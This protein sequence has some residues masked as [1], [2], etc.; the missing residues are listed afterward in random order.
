MVTSPSSQQHDRPHRRAAA[1]G[2]DLPVRGIEPAGRGTGSVRRAVRPAAAIRC[3][4]SRCRRAPAHT[5]IRLHRAAA[6]AVVTPTIPATPAAARPSACGPATAAISRCSTMPARRRPS[7][8]G[9][10]ARPARPWCSPAARSITRVAPNGTRYAD[11]DNA[12]V[13]RDRVVANCTCNGKDGLGLARLNTIDRS[14]LAPGRYRGD[15]RRPCELPGQELQDR[16]IH[17]DQSVRRARGRRSCPTSRSGRRRRTRRW[18][19]RRPR[20][21]RPKSRPPRTA[22]ALKLAR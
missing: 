8:A 16:G 19:W 21:R 20:T 3:G 9:R 18:R 22:A 15:Q 2:G 14:D 13:Y 7:F 1:H 11:L 5:P 12:F 4:R 17:A 6:T 10:S